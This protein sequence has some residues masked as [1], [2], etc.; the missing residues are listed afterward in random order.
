MARMTRTQ[1]TLE[2]EEYLFLKA[3]AVESGASLSS[4]VRRLVRASMQ[5]ASADAPHIW[6]IAGLVGES[7]FTGKDHD[8]VLY[9]RGPGQG[10]GGCA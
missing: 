10:T 1:I 5:D 6:D 7:D 2:E 9:G 8:A 4:I 3:Q